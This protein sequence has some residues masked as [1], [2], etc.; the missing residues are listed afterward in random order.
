[1]ALK[2]RSPLGKTALAGVV[3]FSSAINVAHAGRAME[4]CVKSD[5]AVTSEYTRVLKVKATQACP[6][7]IKVASA[8][9]DNEG[10]VYYTYTRERPPECKKLTQQIEQVVS[11]A[12]KTC[13]RK[14]VP[15]NDISPVASR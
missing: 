12:R 7:D 4:Q 3:A 6:P 1:M 2:E 8:V 5:P 10:G 9:V 14:G 11:N 15:P 13:L